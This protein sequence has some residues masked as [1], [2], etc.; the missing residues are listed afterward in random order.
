MVVVQVHPQ[1]L[2]EAARSAEYGQLTVHM[3]AAVEAGRIPK[4]LLLVQVCS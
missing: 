2:D 4:H 1:A 3:N